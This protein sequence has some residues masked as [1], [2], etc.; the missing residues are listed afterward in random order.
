MWLHGVWT[1][2]LNIADNIWKQI[3]HLRCK[4]K[5]SCEIC[6]WYAHTSCIFSNYSFEWMYGWGWD[7]WIICYFCVRV[8]NCH[9]V[10]Y[11]D[12]TNLHSQQQCRRAPFLHT[13]CNTCYLDIFK[14]WPFWPVWGGISLKFWFAF[15]WQLTMR[16]NGRKNQYLFQIFLRFFWVFLDFFALLCYN[17][18]NK[19]I[20]AVHWGAKAS[21]S[22][23]FGRSG[24]RKRRWKSA[25]TAITVKVGM[26]IGLWHA[27]KL[28]GNLGG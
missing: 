15:L 11:S 12:C 9:T 4:S 28:L 24:I 10:L 7:C 2:S 3:W 5:V 26:L 18:L 16:P 6:S 19:R 23:V 1:K 27:K 17:S 20:N 8:W 13:L 21:L 25:A 22:G 14:W